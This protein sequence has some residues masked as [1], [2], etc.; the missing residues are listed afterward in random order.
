VGAA[1]QPVRLEHGRAAV[2]R[3]QHEVGAGD[4]VA[5][6]GDRTDG[7]AEA[8]GHAG[9]EALAVAGVAAV[10]P[11]L[12]QAGTHG[13]GRHHLRLGLLAGTDDGADAH[14]RARHAINGD[15]ANRT[16]AQDAEG[17]ADH[18]AAQVAAHAVPDGDELG[19]RGARPAEGLVDTEAGDAGALVAARI[20]AADREDELAAIE[21]DAVARRRDQAALG[22]GLQAAHDDRNEIGHA[23]ER[24]HL[25]IG[26]DDER[27][28]AGTLRRVT[29]FVHSAR[30]RPW[31]PEAPLAGRARESILPR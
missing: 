13:D 29:S 21:R 12:L 25:G 10:D 20:D 22:L 8:G 11:D 16:G 15:A 5:C 24:V 7:P 18:Q 31:S 28:H 9:G 6:C 17:L 4:G 14:I 30:D 19:A 26:Q 1:R 27:V 23:R 3:A 2:G